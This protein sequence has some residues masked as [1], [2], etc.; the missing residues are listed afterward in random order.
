M[1]RYL[2]P[3]VNPRTSRGPFDHLQWFAVLLVSENGC[4]GNQK[5]LEHV[6]H[7]I[8]I[9]TNWLLITHGT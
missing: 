9:S 6:Q 5:L 2:L 8:V 7:Q 3:L 4:H 1:A